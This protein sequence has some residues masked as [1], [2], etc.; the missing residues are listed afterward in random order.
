MS[1]KV[2]LSFKNDTFLNNEIVVSGVLKISYIIMYFL[3]M[4]D[5]IYFLL[6]R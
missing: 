1:Q 5:R 6:K 3:F 4:F 2:T